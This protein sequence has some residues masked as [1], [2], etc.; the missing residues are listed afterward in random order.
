MQS[1]AVS[2]WITA[3]VAL[4]GAGAVAVTPVS[5][6][7]PDIQIPAIQLT[8]GPSTDWLDIF[9]TSF[10]NLGQ[11]GAEWLE[12]PFPVAQQLLVNQIGYGTTIFDSL[13]QQ[14]GLLIDPQFPAN[15]GPQ[16]F[17]DFLS[18]GNVGDAFQALTLGSRL[19]G[20]LTYQNFEDVLEIP[21]QMLQ[22]VTN[23]AGSVSNSF[24]GNLG[25]LGLLFNS[26]PLDSTINAFGAALQPLIDDF[27]DPLATIQNIINIP[28]MLTD[29]FLN[30][31]GDGLFGNFSAG[32]TS[33]TTADLG[34][35]GALLVELPQLLAQM[36]GWN[37]VGMPLDILSM[38]F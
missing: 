35:I 27:G 10:N 33:F 13:G 20:T 15:M 23:L 1:L 3:G 31:Y 26:G 4:V 7:L 37:G 25:S 2:P 32:L 38:L 22:N 16:A 18:Q 8:A 12:A 29:G 28:A 14:L 17:F 19:L 5:P 24:V 21:S 6:P 36:I 9:G 30:G 11:I 34:T